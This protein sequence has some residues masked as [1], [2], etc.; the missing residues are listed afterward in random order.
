MRLLCILSAFVLVISITGCQTGPSETDKQIVKRLDKIDKKL[1]MLDKLVKEVKELKEELEEDDVPLPVRQTLNSHKGPNIRR[2][3]KIKL[4]KNASRKEVRD[5]IIKIINASQGQSIYSPQHIQVYMLRKIGS[6]NADLLIDYAKNYYVQYVLPSLVTE[7]NKKQILKSLEVYPQLIT[8]V[9]KMGWGKDAKK[10]IFERLNQTSTNYLPYQWINIAVTLAT[11]KEYKTLENYFIY[12][13]SPQVSY[14]ALCQLE[15]FNMRKAVD[16]AWKRQKNAGQAWSRKQMA[17]IA[18]KF[19]HKDA[20]KYLIY[21]YRTETQQYMI[22]QTKT[23][24]YQLTG[25]ILTPRQMIKWYKN[26]E[27]KLVFDPEQGRY[28][29]KGKKVKKSPVKKNISKMSKGPDYL[30]LNKIKLAKKPTKKQVTEYIKKVLAA[31]K[32]QNRYGSND[33]QIAM[34]SKV[35][36][37]NVDLLIDNIKNYYVNCAIANV[38]TE[39]NKKQILEAFKK[40]HELASCIVKKNW[41]KDAK[42]TIF[43][44]VK[45]NNKITGYRPHVWANAV[46]QAAS[47]KEYPLIEDFFANAGNPEMIYGILGGLED[48]DMK[49]A[50]DKG[51][52]KKKNQ[53]K[54]Y[55]KGNMAIIAA[56]YGNKD[57]L[58][59]LACNFGKEKNKYLARDMKNTVYQLTRKNYSSEKMEKWFNANEKNLVFVPDDEEYIIRKK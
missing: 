29:I 38:A 18:A 11:P 55:S 43:K 32:G 37:D 23:A 47:P 21:S 42:E 45:D 1:S 9:E 8:C 6:K 19:G 13:Q 16:K 39:K 22:D 20:L 28:I 41:G 30:L 15:G 46:V 10:I 54:T 50:A 5:Y 58:K 51:W 26:N 33:P 2:L 49:K 27:S 25:E 34:L 44:Y 17:N 31:S 35:G 14:K 3:K 36:S 57:A 7:K 40:H 59:Y 24:I 4:A 52:A 53:R 12:G 48:F 56:K